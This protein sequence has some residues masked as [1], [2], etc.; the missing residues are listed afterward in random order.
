[1]KRN[2]TNKAWMRQ[3]VNDFY[4][5][6]AKHLG[7]RSRA[8]FKLI[9][10]NERDRLLKPGMVL[11]DLGAAPGGWSQYAAK[12][13]SPRGRV[14]AVDKSEMDDIHGVTFIIIATD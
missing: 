11:V 1:M 4:V 6:Q 9:E 3:H 7:Y 13:V 10:I 14:I 8:A 12:C 2:K 5:K